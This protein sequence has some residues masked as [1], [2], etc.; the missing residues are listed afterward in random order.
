MGM[1]MRG[2]E[3][4][5]E[6]VEGILLVKGSLQVLLLLAVVGT[7]MGT[8]GNLWELEGIQLVKGSLL[9]L[10]L[11]AVV[12]ILMATEGD[13]LEGEVILLEG[14]GILMGIGGNFMMKE[15]PLPTF[16]MATGV[17]L[18]IEKNTLKEMIER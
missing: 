1:P 17:L 10:L 12:G 16:N 2:P 14:E 6:E 3:K 11:L 9:L 15:G 18:V 5:M 8:E 7:L 4:L 13:L